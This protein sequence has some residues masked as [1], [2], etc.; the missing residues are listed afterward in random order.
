MTVSRVA[1]VLVLVLAGSVTA[2]WLNGPPKAPAGLSEWAMH[3]VEGKLGY[4]ASEDPALVLERRMLFSGWTAWNVA[5]GGFDLPLPGERGAALVA[6]AGEPQP[7]EWTHDA[8]QLAI[9]VRLAEVRSGTVIHSRD[10][11]AHVTVRRSPG[12][13]TGGFSLDDSVGV[14]LVPPG[15]HAST[16]TGA[17]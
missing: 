12:Q 9:P 15:H 8:W 10:V 6:T 11:I 17:G 5:P 7:P 2:N 16:R 3:A 1:A 13:D 14:S 4:R